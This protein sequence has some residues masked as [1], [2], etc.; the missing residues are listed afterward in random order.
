MRETL[1]LSP[2]APMRSVRSLESTTIGGGKYRIEP[3][4]TVVQNT[5]FMHRDP[6]V[7]GDD[8]CIRDPHPSKR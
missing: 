7:W 4:E 3:D 5:F 2:T 1:R 6:T 8:V